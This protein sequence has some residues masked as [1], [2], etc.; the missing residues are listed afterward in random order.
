MKHWPDITGIDTEQLIEEEPA[1]GDADEPVDGD[2]RRTK[3]SHPGVQSVKRFSA[4]RRR[5]RTDR[6]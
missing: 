5:S 2:E 4:E 3:K 1:E 6:A